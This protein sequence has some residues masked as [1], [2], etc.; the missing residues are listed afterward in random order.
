MTHSLRAC[1][2]PAVLA[3]LVSSARADDGWKLLFGAGMEGLS[4]ADQL[5]IYRHLGLKR[6]ADGKDLLVMGGE[7]AGPARFTVQL[8]DLN[9]DGRDEVFVIG[10]NAFLSG[11]SGSSVWLFLKP[12]PDG[13]WQVNLGVP[14]ASYTVL[15]QDHA[16]YPDLRLPGTGACDAVWR[17]D[18]DTYAYHQGV[19]TRPGGCDH[20]P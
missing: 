20:L 19:A 18:G 2:F 12:A 8:E 7:A 14:A 3:L 16:G 11:A 9:A 10:G 13:Q 17:W 4:E 5:A 15:A 1:L 6:S